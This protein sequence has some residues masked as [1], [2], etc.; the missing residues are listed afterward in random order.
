MAST[1]NVKWTGDL[2]GG[3]GKIT[4]GSGAI[5]GTYTAAGRWGEGK[6]TSP[7]ELIAAAHAACFSMSLILILGLAGHTPESVETDA[8]VL[9]KRVDGGFEIPRIELSTVGT[10]SGISEKEFLEHAERAKRECPVS[11]ALA[12]PEIRLE[13]K[14]A[15]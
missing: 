15:G 13:T 3:E 1:A 14:L 2:Q 6:G 12:G 5:G 10:V 11:K 8:K 7:E 4:T 9:L